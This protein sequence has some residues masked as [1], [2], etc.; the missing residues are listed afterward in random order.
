MS[1]YSGAFEAIKTP[2]LHKDLDSLFHHLPS[3][4]TP[5]SRKQDLHRKG[6]S[7]LIQNI[8]LVRLLLPL[9]PNIRMAGD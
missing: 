3:T 2:T 5:K 6:T 4:L 1:T 8:L 7:L 9:L